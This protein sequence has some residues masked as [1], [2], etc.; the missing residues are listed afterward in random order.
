MAE[1]S[2]LP[3]SEMPKPMMDRR[4][5]LHVIIL[6]VGVLLF[7]L[8]T[9]AY[10]LHLDGSMT[11][12]VAVI[13]AVTLSASVFLYFRTLDKV[14]TAG[15]FFC[16]SSLLLYR[17][18]GPYFMWPLHLVLPIIAGLIS[19][20]FAGLPSFFRGFFKV[21]NL[22]KATIF[23]AVITIIG[24]AGALFLWREMT[25]PDISKYRALFP[26]SGLV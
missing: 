3:D 12:A 6:I 24:A 1:K 22:D 15:S 7:P 23:L 4:N 13:C 10:A 14:L 25:N 19:N 21:K 16:L 26:Q 2:V 11:A 20:Y 5:F 18:L 17:F 8:P 9:Y